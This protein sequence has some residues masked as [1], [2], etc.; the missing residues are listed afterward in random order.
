MKTLYCGLLAIIKEPLLHFMLLGALIF[1]AFNI[2]SG[3][4]HDRYGEIVV[5]SATIENLT[6]IFSRTWHRQPAET[7]LNGLIQDYV[8]EEIAVREAVALGLDRDD[9]V[10]RRLLRQKLEFVTEEAALQIE[11]TEA[12]LQQYLLSHPEVFSGEA[13]ISF[14]QIYFN[15]QQLSVKNEADIA[16]LRE[17]LNTSQEQIDATALGDITSLGYQFEDVSISEIGR[18]FGEQFAASLTAVESGKWIGPLKSGY[19][20]HLVK[21]D[22]Y[23]PS[24]TPELA[25]VHD[26]VRREWLNNRRA[27]ALDQF[28]QQRLQNYSVKIDRPEKTPEMHRLAEWAR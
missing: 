14:S 17:R 23:I 6:N 7:E 16:A 13:S 25:Q 15:P 5:T 24:A 21:I 19:G 8:R 1:G 22:R 2:I 11:P 4:Q 9:S 3:E 12:Q 20:L 10:M 28:Y 27:S 26:A 18:L